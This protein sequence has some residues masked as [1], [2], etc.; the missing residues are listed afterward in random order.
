MLDFIFIILSLLLK[1]MSISGRSRFGRQ[2]SK[3]RKELKTPASQIKTLCTEAIQRI[4]KILASTCSSENNYLS[5][6]HYIIHNLYENSIELLYPKKLQQGSMLVSESSLSIALYFFCLLFGIK[7]KS[8]NQYDRIFE[9]ELKLQITYVINKFALKNGPTFKHIF[10][11]YV[12]NSLFK[13]ENTG[14]DF[15]NANLVFLDLVKSEM[16]THCKS[17]VKEIEINTFEFSHCG[18]QILYTLS[19]LA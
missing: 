4:E 6:L 7:T 18:N 17:T 19:T 11:I 15:E 8:F 14:I 9:M 5:N 2:V 13:F 16:S 1:G 12:V 3:K 10:F